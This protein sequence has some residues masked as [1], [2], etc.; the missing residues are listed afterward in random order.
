MFRKGEE[1]VEENAAD[2]A[3]HEVH[4]PTTRLEQ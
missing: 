2:N 3:E 1:N 4:I